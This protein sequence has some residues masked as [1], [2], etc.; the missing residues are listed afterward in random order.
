[1]NVSLFI[2]C[3]A[4]VFYPNVGKDVVEV[5]ERQGCTVDFPGNQT[6]CGQPA[7]NSGYHK[8]TKEVA[9]K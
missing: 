8:E 2:T 5:L 6:C 9:K 4:D 1:M 3:L 7:F